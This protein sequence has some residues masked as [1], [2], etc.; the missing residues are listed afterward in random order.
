VELERD[1]E[2]LDAR[3]ES[4][5]S[6]VRSRRE[7]LA[8]L[9]RSIPN[10]EKRLDQ[11]SAAAPALTAWA[12]QETKDYTIGRT[13][14][15]VRKDA[16]DRL[17]ESL[18]EAY[19][20]LRGAGPHESAHV[21]TFADVPLHVTR[22]MEH[23]MVILR[24]GDL[25][26]VGV[27]IT[28][29]QLWPQR[30][31]SKFG[32]WGAGNSEALDV[33]VEDANTN[34]AAMANGVM[35]RIENAIARAPGQ[36]DTARTELGAD[37]RRLD[38]LHNTPDE[39]FPDAAKLQLMKTEL[40][41]I[42]DDLAAY[43]NSDAAQ[44]AQTEL[45]QRLAARGRSA[46]WSLMLNPTPALV[47]ELGFD[48]AD[49]VREMMRHREVEALE[50]WSSL[51]TTSQDAAPKDVFTTDAFT[52][53]AFSTDPFSTDAFTTSYL[54]YRAQEPEIDTSTDWHKPGPFSSPAPDCEPDI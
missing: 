3:R 44:L 48:T 19:V 14:V 50:A 52:T 21:A 46:G 49:E 8:A 51:P 17:L 32:L 2:G 45:E 41:G 7:E 13:T 6:E 34:R 23:D 4:H 11:L 31:D 39:P 9:T 20:Q 16:S 53:D 36:I 22:V 47:E 40:A 27:S 38:E 33:E 37:R 1:I 43:E 10:D 12:E 24:F 28:Q 35:T 42:N 18:R 26:M 30:S 29:E 25:P 5:L 54:K 15:N